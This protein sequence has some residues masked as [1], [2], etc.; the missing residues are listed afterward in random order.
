MNTV[1]LSKGFD[2]ADRAGGLLALENA[3]ATYEDILIQVEYF[4]NG[5]FKCHSALCGS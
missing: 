3:A 5:I 1:T 2:D 4:F